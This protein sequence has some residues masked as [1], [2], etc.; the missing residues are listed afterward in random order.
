MSSSFVPQNSHA[1]ALYE[2]E[3]EETAPTNR[4][5]RGECDFKRGEYDLGNNTVRTKM[6]FRIK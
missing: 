6:L 5:R 2:I 1:K 4:H 3:S